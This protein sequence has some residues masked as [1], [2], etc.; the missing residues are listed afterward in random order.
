MNCVNHP[1][2]EVKAYC[3]QCGKPMCKEC[4]RTV[5]GMIY[6]EPCLAARLG[7]PA[8]GQVSANLSTGAPPIPLLAGLLGFIPGVGAMYNG[9]FVKALAH[10]VIFAVF[11]SLADRSVIFGFLIAGWVFYQAFDAYHTAKARLEGLPLPNPFGLNDL[12]S[13]FGIPHTPVAGGP[14]YGAGFTPGVPPQSGPVAGPAAS[15]GQPSYGAG[16]PYAP[17]ASYEAAVPPEPP[18]PSKAPVGAIVLIVLGLFLL[19]Q[20]LGIFQG[21]WIDRTWPLLIVGLG[22]WLLYRRTHET[23][24]GG[25]Q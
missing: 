2:A 11:V 19:F 25:S 10:V 8:E 5:G 17:P 15:A 3:Q 16:M 6:C 22:A 14:P 12:G 24:R 21:E 23:P 1:G 18:V 13:R 20:T 9:Q 7:V 4:M